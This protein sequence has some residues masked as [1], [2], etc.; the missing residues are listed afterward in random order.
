S[1]SALRSALASAKATLPPWRMTFWSTAG[2]YPSLVN[3]R[4]SS[5]GEKDGPTGRA[6][7]AGT[8]QADLAVGDGEAACRQGLVRATEP[9]PR[10]LAVGTGGRRVGRGVSGGIG[11][12][13]LLEKGNGELLAQI[14]GMLLALGEGNE[15]IVGS[16]GEHQVE[17]R[18][19]LGYKAAAQFLAVG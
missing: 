15:V 8:S 1:H 18:G 11:I 4:R 10:P 14:M 13:V 17:G 12:G 16:L 7:V 2:E 6:A 5:R 19:C 9:S 3:C